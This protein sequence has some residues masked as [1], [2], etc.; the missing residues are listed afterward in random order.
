[1]DSKKLGPLSRF[2]A[3]TAHFHRIISAQEVDV[4][5]LPRLSVRWGK[6]VG[7]HVTI[8]KPANW[9]SFTSHRCHPHFSGCWRK[10]QSRCQWVR[11]K[12]SGPRP[13]CPPF[14]LIQNLRWLTRFPTN[15]QPSLSHLWLIGSPW[16]DPNCFFPWG[17]NFSSSTTV[18]DLFLML[19][20]AFLTIWCWLIP[21]FYAWISNLFVSNSSEQCPNQL[22]KLPRQWL[23]GRPSWIVIVLDIQRVQPPVRPPPRFPIVFPSPVS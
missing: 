13:L 20:L 21:S 14:L 12:K 16:Q 18:F 9:G 3:V 23:V 19:E 5:A 4:L 17:H 7:N 8:V 6:H 11:G 10:T 1:M 22:G 2:A 15:F